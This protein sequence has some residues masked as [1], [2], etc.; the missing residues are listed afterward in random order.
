MTGKEYHSEGKG[1]YIRSNWHK[2]V[3]PLTRAFGEIP[4]KGLVFDRTF[5]QNRPKRTGK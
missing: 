4:A 1:H 5:R 3:K 2:D